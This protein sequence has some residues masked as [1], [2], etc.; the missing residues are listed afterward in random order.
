MKRKCNAKQMLS[1]KALYKHGVSVN[2]LFMLWVIYHPTS[3]NWFTNK[4]FFKSYQ[5]KSFLRLVFYSFLLTYYNKQEIG[6]QAFHNILIEFDKLVFYIALLYF[7][8]LFF[9]FLFYKYFNELWSYGKVF[10]KKKKEQEDYKFVT[11]I[12]IQLFHRK[13]KTIFGLITYVCEYYYNKFHL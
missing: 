1:T 2:I 8:F 13:K 4:M 11:Y 9:I 12:Y 7:L 6:T 3:C 10:K 5:K